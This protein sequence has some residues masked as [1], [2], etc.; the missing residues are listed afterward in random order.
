MDWLTLVAGADARESIREEFRAHRE[1]CVRRL[2]DEGLAPEAAAAEASRRFGEEEPY[3]ELCVREV[4]A[5]RR[6][7]IRR[8]AAVAASTGLVL[9]LAFYL[10]GDAS[11]APF[12]R[13][14]C[15]HLIYGLPL[16]LAAGACAAR[17][18][19]W[20]VRL[21]LAFLGVLAFWAGIFLGTHMGYGAWQAVPDPPEAAFV[22]GA[23]LVG[24]LIAGWLPG[25]F[26]VVLA[27]LVSSL[28]RRRDRATPQAPLSP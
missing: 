1:E 4:L 15:L 6:G 8:V 16:A 22:D 28:F 18:R 9:V 12:R 3:V 10:T 25:M 23:E 2:A 14:F 21:A 20:L 13:V 19:S 5:E 26:V 7:E 17:V 24:A 11:H 27:Y